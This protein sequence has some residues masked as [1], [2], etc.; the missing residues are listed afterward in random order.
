M[1]PITRII[2]Q[3]KQMHFLTQLL[4]LAGKGIKV[5]YIPCILL[6]CI[7]Y[8]HSTYINIYVY[9]YLCMFIVKK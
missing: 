8:L 3:Q 1:G 6:I 9:F 4:E 7:M 2:S 5:S